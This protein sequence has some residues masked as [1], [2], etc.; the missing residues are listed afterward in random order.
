MSILGVTLI[1]KAYSAMQQWWVT[2]DWLQEVIQMHNHLT[3]RVKH[4]LLKIVWLKETIVCASI[5]DWVNG[6]V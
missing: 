4:Y 6:K 3:L 2:G 5:V 1:P